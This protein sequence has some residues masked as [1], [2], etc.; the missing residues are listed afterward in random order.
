[1]DM[2]KILENIKSQDWNQM[3][4][5][6]IALK[7]Y[8]AQNGHKEFYAIS[9]CWGVYANFKLACKHEGFKAI[10]AMHPSL[11]ASGLFGEDEL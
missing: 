1:M 4:A 3:E 9:F 5:R 6:F 8:L 2:P 11:G 10:A 7:E